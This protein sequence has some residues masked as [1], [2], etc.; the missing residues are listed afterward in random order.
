MSVMKKLL[1]AFLL[2]FV[3]SAAYAEQNN[4]IIFKTGITPYSNLDSETEFMFLNGENSYSYNIGLIFYLEYYRKINNLF[5]LGIGISQQ[6][7]REAKDVRNITNTGIYFT[8][9]YLSPKL[10][11]YDEIYAVLHI[12]VGKLNHDYILYTKDKIGGYYALGMGYKYEN[13]IFEFL[14]SCNYAKRETY[15]G[16]V[17]I[18]S[19]Q[20]VY[21]TF[22]F[23][24]GYK[25]TFGRDIQKK[26]KDIKVKE[27]KKTAKERKKSEKQLSI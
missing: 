4:S 11:I 25:F 8:S 24:I 10:K 6:L 1:S 7:Y 13:F 20:D 16:N 5:D 18:I 12:G 26:D 14:F 3:L 23:N 17:V 22:N 9:I 21:Q 15:V 19:R 27:I 2:I